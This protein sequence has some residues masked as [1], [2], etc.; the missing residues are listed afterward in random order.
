MAASAGTAALGFGGLLLMRL[1]YVGCGVL[2][3]AAGEKHTI[4][5]VLLDRKEKSSL[6]NI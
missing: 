1:A 4:R 2:R 5:E 6:Y 3:R